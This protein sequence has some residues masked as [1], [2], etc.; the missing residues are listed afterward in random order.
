[1]V[2]AGANE[3]PEETMLEAIMFGHEEIKRFDCFPRTNCCRN[4]K[5]KVE[6]VLAEVDAELEDEIRESM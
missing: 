1:M 3:V 2:E 6:I 4:W 5:R